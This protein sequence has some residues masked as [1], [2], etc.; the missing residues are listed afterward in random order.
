MFSSFSRRQLLSL[1]GFV[2]I[3][4]VAAGSV[5]FL[6]NFFASIA[7]AQET[8]EFVYKG[9]KYKIVTNLKLDR[10][11]P[12]DTTF[13][14]SEQLFLDDKEINIARNKNTQKYQTHLLFGQFNSPHEVA[15]MLIDQGIK[16]PIGKVK[17][18]P[19]V[20]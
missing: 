7:Q 8:E 14:T 19:N 16:F 3:G 10:T 18:D 11:A 4:T 9:R 17:L 5:P 13:D 6:G 12:I 1:I 2:G 20:D 15:R